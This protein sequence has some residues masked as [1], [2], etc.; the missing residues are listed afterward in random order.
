MG[1]DHRPLSH[2]RSCMSSERLGA[3]FSAVRR[4]GRRRK[5]RETVTA[6]FQARSGGHRAPALPLCC[7]DVHH[8]RSGGPGNRGRPNQK[9]A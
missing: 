5:D 6:A 7:T 2:G 8:A 9:R 3:V 1:A 4:A